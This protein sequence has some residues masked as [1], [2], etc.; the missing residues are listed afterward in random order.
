GGYF[1]WAAVA[2][3]GRRLVRY[4]ARGHGCSTG[5][6]V[7]EDYR[8]P[9]LAEDLLALLDVVSPDRPVDAIG[10]SMGVGTLLHA[11]TLRPERFRRLA[12]VIP[13]TAWSTREAQGDV[14]RQMADL[15]EDQGLETLVRAMQALGTLPLLEAGGFPPPAAPDVAE[16]LLPSVFRGAAVSDLPPSAVLPAITVPVLLRPWI[17]DPGH[18]VSTAQLLHDLLP[19]ATLD[20]TRTPDALRALGGRVA[21]FLR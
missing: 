13:P 9:R 10:V 2:H 6:P 7:P 20:V 18:P 4:D 17:D 11:A 21:D 19:G 1:G 8:W 14:Y 15:V 5:R 12:L 3:S 16:A